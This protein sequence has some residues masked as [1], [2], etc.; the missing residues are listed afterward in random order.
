M[1]LKLT[2]PP[3][4]GSV[5]KAMTLSTFGMVSKSTVVSLC[6]Q[7]LW[8]VCVR[9]CVCMRACICLLSMSW[10][11]LT[12]FPESWSCLLQCSSDQKLTPSSQCSLL[13]VAKRV[14]S[15]SSH[16]H[17]GHS[18]HCTS[19][20]A[21]CSQ[22]PAIQSP[23]VLDSCVYLPLPVAAALILLHGMWTA[24]V[25]FHPPATHLQMT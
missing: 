21:R 13:V 19:W 14:W 6:F 8:C 18:V 7:K 12:Y 10:V 22:A 9:T 3:T 20:L 11:C 23:S 24:L 1:I 5:H 17:H 2:S 4:R 16:S 15:S 25:T